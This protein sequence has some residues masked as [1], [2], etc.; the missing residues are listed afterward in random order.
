MCGCSVNL[1]SRG[2]SALRSG[3]LQ[4]EKTPQGVI[5]FVLDNNIDAVRSNMMADGIDTSQLSKADIQRWLVTSFGMGYDISR[6]IDVPYLNDVDNYTG[7]KIDMVIEKMG[8][9][10]SY[11]IKPWVQTVLGIVLGGIGAMYGTQVFQGQ[12]NTAVPPAPQPMTIPVWVWAIAGVVMLVLVI[13]LL[14][15]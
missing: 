2:A 8:G 11:A 14:R 4:I 6:Y 3:E 9:D 1:P 15:K 7:G 13:A 10:T 5:Q 12:G